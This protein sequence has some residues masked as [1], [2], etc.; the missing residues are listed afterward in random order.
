MARSTHR[1]RVT[2]RGFTACENV[3]LF[4]VG[5]SAGGLRLLMA[6]KHYAW[7]NEGE[8]PT[9]AELA[10]AIGTTERSIRDDFKE[11]E[12]RGLISVERR[13]GTGS[14]VIIESPEESS[15]E[16]SE[17]SS[18]EQRKILP[19][20]TAGV[21]APTSDQGV[22]TLKTALSKESAHASIY[23]ALIEAC[24][25]AGATLTHRAKQ[26]TALA[27]TNIVSGGGI[28]EM[29][30]AVRRAYQAHSSYSKC[31]LTPMALSNRWS[32]LAPVAMRA[33]CDACG[34]TGGRHAVGCE[35]I[36]A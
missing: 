5:L 17:A 16:P 26:Q 10:A 13:Q 23:N 12:R 27:A 14:R 9:Q 36:A 34:I 29:V 33:P 18:G 21:R 3:Y 19:G 28:A 30:P 2:Q 20:L 22:K 11:L 7:K 25:P 8:I 35:R 32:E 24:F 6:L 15:G 1:S 4:D 31:A